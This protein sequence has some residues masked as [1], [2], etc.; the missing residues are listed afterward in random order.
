MRTPWNLIVLREHIRRSRGKDAEALEEIVKSIRKS[1][2]IFRYHLITARDALKG[3]LGDNPSV[4]RA[5]EIVWREQPSEYR[6]AMIVS[7][8]HILGCFLIT[9]NMY[10]IFAQLVNRLV[11][12]SSLSDRDCDIWKVYEELDASDLRTQIGQL[13]DSDW[14][15]Y[16]SAFV[17][18]IKHRSLVQ[19]NFRVSFEDNVAGIILGAFEFKSRSHPS[20]S[21]TEALEGVTE[22]KNRIVVCGRVLNAHCG[23]S[24]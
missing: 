17:N 14:F 5:L 18:T 6:Y 15:G 9:R 8:A 10:D 4:D 19:H 20:Y 7:E 16:V 2:D 24:P 13:L 21:A 11:L 23:L 12:N 22:V 1:V 3:I